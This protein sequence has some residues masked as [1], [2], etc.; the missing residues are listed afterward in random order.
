MRICRFC[1]K[2]TLGR[3]TAFNGNGTIRHQPHWTSFKGKLK[4]RKGKL[5]LREMA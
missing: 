4:L 5:K 3:K 2:L 1:L